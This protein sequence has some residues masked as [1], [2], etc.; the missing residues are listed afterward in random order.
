MLRY[1]GESN[2]KRMALECGG[3][4]PQVVFADAD[5]KAAADDI[6]WG[7][8]YNSGETCH[9]GSRLHRARERQGGTDR[10]A[11]PRS[12][13]PSPWATRSSPTTQMGA[14]IDHGHMQRVLG[15]IDGGVADGARVA[16]GGHR[17][18][19]ESGGF[20]IEATVLDGVRPADEGRAR[21]D[22]RPGALG[23]DVQGRERRGAAG[24]RHPA[25]GWPPR[26]GPPT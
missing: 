13:P 11:S 24:Q 22:L 9:A 6:A 19:E 4:T 12:P 15:Y 20:Y 16:L 7:I 10:G 26:Y 2:L 21:G 5:L 17:A 18:L 23:H 8:Y 1:A 3:K 14:L 25:S